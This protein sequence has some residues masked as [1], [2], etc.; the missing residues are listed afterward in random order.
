[1]AF[2][3]RPRRGPRSAADTAATPVR[4][5]GT[6][7]GCRLTRAV[8][9]HDFPSPRAFGPGSPPS[10]PRLGELF[11]QGSAKVEA[12]CLSL[13]TFVVL[14]LMML[15]LNFIGEALR[16]AMDPRKG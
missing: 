12:G 6:A 7:R 13:S 2:A 11:R 3:R 1:M 5:G 4:A 15:L 16:D 14:G 10:T 8:L 9:T